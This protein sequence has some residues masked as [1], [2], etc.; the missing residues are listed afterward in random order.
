MLTSTWRA[1]DGSI[2]IVLVNYTLDEAHARLRFDP[3]DWGIE[4]AAPSS[5]GNQESDASPKLVLLDEDGKEL[6]LERDG[7]RWITPEITLRPERPG[8]VLQLRRP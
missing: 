4:L 6:A 1:P 7:D 8:T 3:A 5:D 2:G